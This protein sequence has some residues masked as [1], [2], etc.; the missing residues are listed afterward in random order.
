MVIW[1]VIIKKGEI[2]DSIHGFDDNKHKCII[3]LSVS[4]V[5]FSSI[6]PAVVIA[7]LYFNLFALVILFRW[8]QKGED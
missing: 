4:Q 1:F 6:T 8:C 5:N 3:C 2:V 7:N